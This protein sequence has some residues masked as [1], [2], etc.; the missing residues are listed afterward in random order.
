MTERLIETQAIHN[1]I[2]ELVILLKANESKAEEVL[3]LYANLKGAF[4]LLAW[5]EVPATWIAKITMALGII[6][7]LW[8]FVFLETISRS[9][10]K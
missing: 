6:W 4:R 9:Q 7:G 10:V 1:K 5:I 8:K 2:D 3:T